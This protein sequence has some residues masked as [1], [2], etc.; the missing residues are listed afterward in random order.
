MTVVYVVVEQIGELKNGNVSS[1]TVP[2]YILTFHSTQE[3]ALA[4]SIEIGNAGGYS[5]VEMRE[6]DTLNSHL[7]I[8][9]VGE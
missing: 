3:L 6:L 9:P 7:A 4:R 2:R 1:N 8:T 5:H